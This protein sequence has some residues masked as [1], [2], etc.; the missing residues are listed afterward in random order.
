[1]LQPFLNRDIG[2]LTTL[3][4]D[5]PTAACKGKCCDIAFGTVGSWEMEWLEGPASP[6]EEVRRNAL[7]RRPRPR[8]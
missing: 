6:A 7:G 5:A 4:P 1:M 3:P 8:Q 2:I